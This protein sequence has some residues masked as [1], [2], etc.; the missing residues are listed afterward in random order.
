MLSIITATY[1]RPEL[2]RENCLDSLLKQSDTNFEWVV[3]N[4]GKNKDTKKIVEKHFNDLNIVY[5][6]IMHKGVCCARNLGLKLASGDYISYLD[7]DNKLADDYVEKINNY[8]SQNSDVKMILPIRNQRRDVYKDNVLVKTGKEFTQ[9]KIGATDDDFLEERSNAF[10]DSN[11]FVHKK[12]SS[13]HFNEKLLILSD[14]ELLL[15]CYSLWGLNS[16]KILNEKLV[17]YIQRSYG[18][19]GRSRYIDWA[20]ELEYI[21]KSKDKYKVFKNYNSFDWMKEKI[22]EFYDKA[23]RNESLRGFESL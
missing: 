2:L 10:F 8:I 1:D 23:G 19:I 22:E 15:Q 4:D 17:T 18:I 6:E 11:G 7:D 16:L 5:K 20:K 9:P 21:Y 3:I 13:L 12:N 14:Y